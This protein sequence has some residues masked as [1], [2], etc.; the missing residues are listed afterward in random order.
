VFPNG[1]TISLSVRPT[2][3][4]ENPSE[5]VL[6]DDVGL[7]ATG[8]AW[9][10]TDGKLVGGKGGSISLIADRGNSA[11]QLGDGIDLEAYGVNGADGGSLS[12]ST[13]RMEIQSGSVWAQ[14]QR[15]DPT[16]YDD[17]RIKEDDESVRAVR[18]GALTLGTSLFTDHG[19]SH[20]TLAANGQVTT[21]D[22]SDAFVVRDGS[23]F[24]LRVR[25]LEV[26]DASRTRPSGGTIADFSTVT[27]EPD[28]DRGPVDVTFRVAAL[29]TAFPD[30][31]G[32]MV[33]EAGT[34]FAADAGSSFTFS[35]DNGVCFDGRVIAPSG[36]VTLQ[37]SG[38]RDAQLDP[39]YQPG[40]QLEVGADASI[41][42]SGIAL[43]APSDRGLR[44]GSVLDGGSISLLASRGSV[45][46]HSGA[47]FSVAGTSSA[48]DLKL[49]DDNNLYTRKVV[50][51]GA[52]SFE[53]RS[54]EAIAFGGMLDAHAGV[55]E[56]GTAHGGT[57]TVALT[58]VP[59][60]GFTAPNPGVGVPFPDAANVVHV[61]DSPL[62][63][64]GPSSGQAFVTT[65]LIKS[66]GIDALRLESDGTVAFDPGVS[67][68]LGRSLTVD[69]PGVSLPVGGSVS[70]RAP[71]VAFGNT[72]TEAG[73]IP[74]P[75][76][77]VGGGQ[78]DVH[79]DQID[80]FGTTNLLRIGQASFA[81]AGDIRL[82]GV[83]ISDS[84]GA[85]RTNGDLTLQSE[86][87]YPS[88]STTF[89]L[90]ATGGTNNT[91]RILQ[92]GTSPGAPLSAAGSLTVSADN[93]VQGGSLY[94][95]FGTIALNATNKLSLLCLL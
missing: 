63:L 21:K 61:I 90:S 9:R 11:F 16:V 88:T 22:P 92:D 1:G 89:T 74:D 37:T 82:R 29:D 57:L 65:S 93:I 19:F 62:V 58:R 23:S 49:G 51:S 6:G 76:I 77:D 67:V 20:F 84:V 8:G 91:I 60:R 81:S 73:S 24:D 42:T 79:G 5:L 59:S 12:I 33:V 35:G 7:L 52:G 56:T 36:K 75:V 40:L 83:G 66:T 78:L 94:A 39:G 31:S 25:T 32:R 4:D 3:S 17:P 47:D 41:N 26:N 53:L 15:L 69:S 10:Q 30:R 50:A 48:L 55:G 87:L 64:G 80:L 95:P 70:L 71:Y 2:R 34:V 54:G 18:E 43:I 46:V 28:I 14:A 85:L 27:L 68:S 45:N 13:T 86:R 72:L 44:I 38:P